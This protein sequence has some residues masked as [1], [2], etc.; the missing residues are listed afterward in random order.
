MPS[1]S[2]DA[3]SFLTI[4]TESI[5]AL[6]AM[7]G[8]SHGCPSKGKTMNYKFDGYKQ[9]MGLTVNGV[10]SNGSEGA[11]IAKIKV[12]LPP[13]YEIRQRV[14]KVNDTT[15]SLENKLTDRE[16]WNALFWI[17]VTN[18]LTVGPKNYLDI[19]RVEDCSEIPVATIDIS[20]VHQ[21]GQI[22]GG[23]PVEKDYIFAN[24]LHPTKY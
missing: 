4:S 18:E 23:S 1:V 3:S 7:S 19:V 5:K 8:T 10:T 6:K 16:Y 24:V 2:F 13:G 15:V 11:Y 22:V 20:D 12:D 9:P 14:V 17:K 21:K